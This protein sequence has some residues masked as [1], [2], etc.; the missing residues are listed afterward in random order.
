LRDG[1]G[2]VHTVPFSA[3][4]SIVNTARDFSN[5]IFDIGVAYDQDIDKV[6]KIMKQVGEELRQEPAFKHHILRPIEVLGLDSM[7][8][9][10]M[11]IK[12]QIRTRPADKG[13]VIR[14]FNLRLKRAFDEHGIALPFPQ[15]MMQM[16]PQT[17]AAAAPEELSLAEAKAVQNA[18]AGR[19]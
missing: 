2:A 4:S 8:N 10:A 16:L 11:V 14:A 5:A 6:I 12:A 18:Q 17:Q 15:R 9:G 19:R 1:D 3:V 13:A 7:Q